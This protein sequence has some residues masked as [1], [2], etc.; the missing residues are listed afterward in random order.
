MLSNVAAAR[1]RGVRDGLQQR[2]L[3]RKV[4]R[5]LPVCTLSW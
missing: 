1:Y 4:H 3:E 2:C 5:V